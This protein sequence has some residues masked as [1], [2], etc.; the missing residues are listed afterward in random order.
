MKL[1]DENTVNYT[2]G[3]QCP[4]CATVNSPARKV[5]NCQAAFCAICDE[6]VH[7]YARMPYGSIYDDEIICV[8]C[9]DRYLG[10]ALKEATRK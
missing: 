3:W 10:D 2:V 7:F 6:W 8:D 5:C 1:T 9:L 4:E